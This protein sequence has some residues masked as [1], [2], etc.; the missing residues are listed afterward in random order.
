MT[1][2]HWREV[3]KSFPAKLEVRTSYGIRQGFKY[4]KGVQICDS[5]NALLVNTQPMQTL[6]Q[7]EADRIQCN[8]DKAHPRLD[9]GFTARH[10]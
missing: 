1:S 9:R 7:C 8:G 5:T 3:L 6:H 4:S 2:G 10:Q